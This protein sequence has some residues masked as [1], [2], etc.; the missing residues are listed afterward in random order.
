MKKIK[1]VIFWVVLICLLVQVPIMASAESS[2][3]TVPNNV[4]TEITNEQS[5]FPQ[6][7]D[8]GEWVYS[9]ELYA[10]SDTECRH[11]LAE[12]SLF[13]NFTQPGKYTLKYLLHYKK[14]APTTYVGEYVSTTL[15]VVDT[16]APTLALKGKNYKKKYEIGT[17]L[18]IIGVDVT[19]NAKYIPTVTVSAY[20]EDKLISIKN[21]KLLLDELGSYKIVYKAVDESGNVSELVC[22][23]NVVEKVGVT[24]VWLIV[25]VSLG[26]VAVIGVAVFF[27]IKHV[28]KKK[29]SKK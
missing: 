10:E 5:W 20:K 23:F 6:L 9:V 13:Y 19:D 14:D 29:G 15:H 26:A 21:D 24:S 4:Y 2:L 18:S 16:T 17:E 27:I 1:K 25:G 22:E 8:S 11:N 12:N 3:T 28:K 7:V